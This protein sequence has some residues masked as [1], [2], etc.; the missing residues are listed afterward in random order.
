M[1]RKPVKDRCCLNLDCALHGQ[2]GKG[3]IIR[4]SFYKTSQGRRRRYLCKACK[5]TFGSTAGTP[6]YRL[7]KPRSTFDE[8]ATMAVEG[9]GI[10]A[11][12]RITGLAPDTVAHWR[13]KASEHADRFND[14]KLK[15]F[16]L[17]ELQADEMR[18]FVARRFTG[19]NSRVAF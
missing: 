18:S 17:T 10:S 16:D 12:A 4:H 6:Y 9:V 2:F 14:R 11:T 13:E 7:Q 15:G 19:G 8:V 3:N 5:K 1:K